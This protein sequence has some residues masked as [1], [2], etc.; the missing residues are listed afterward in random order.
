MKHEQYLKLLSYLKD[1]IKDIESSFGDDII[2][3][4][5]AEIQELKGFITTLELIGDGK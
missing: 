5:V 1:R 3:G 4:E 2:Y